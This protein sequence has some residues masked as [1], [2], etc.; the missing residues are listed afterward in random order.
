MRDHV[1]MQFPVERLLCLLL[2]V[3][4]DFVEGTGHSSTIKLFSNDVAVDC[5]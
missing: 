1:M 2:D 4:S 3:I 5:H